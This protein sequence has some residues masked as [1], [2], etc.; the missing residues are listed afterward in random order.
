MD[1]YARIIVNVPQVMGEFDYQIPPEIQSRVK[2]GCLVKVPFGKQF[3]QG[4]VFSL[5]DSSEWQ[6]AK[7][8]QALLDDEPVLS[9]VQLLLARHLANQTLSSLAACI[10]MMLPPG[11]SQQADTL[12]SLNTYAHLSLPDFSKIQQRII[13]LIQQ[14]G[15]LR[16]RQLESAF[17]RIRWK[18]A[19]LSLVKSGMLLNQPVL[20]VSKVR[21]KRVRMVTLSIP[22]DTALENVKNFSKTEGIIQRRQSALTFLAKEN[23]PVQTTWVAAAS[24]CTL[25]DL[26][27]LSDEGLISLEELEIWRDPLDQVEAHPIPPPCLTAEQK[28]A[29]EKILDG[30]KISQQGKTPLPYL[31]HGVTSSG[32]TEIYLHAVQEVLN[33]DRQAIILVPEISLTPQTVNRFLSRFPG[34]VGLVHSKLSAGERYDTWR[35]ARAGLLQVVVGPRSALF[36]PFHDLGLIVIDECHDDSYFQDDAQPAYSAVEAALIFARI[37]NAVIVLG[38]ATPSLDLVY[39]ANKEGWERLE[40][41]VRI[42]AHRDV[43][44]KE[45]EALHQPVPD[46]P[47]KKVTTILPLPPVGIIDMRDELKS[48]NRSIFSFGLQKAL[49]D[50]LAN[51]QQAILFLN[52]RGSATYIFCRNCGYSLRCPRCDLP[53]TYHMD[54]NQLLCHT[55]GYQRN[56]PLR[57]PKCSSGQIKQY[58]TGTE[59]VEQTLKELF[60]SANLLRWDFETTRQ[61]GSHDLILAH[62]IRHN[63]DILIGT[64][65]LAKGLDLPL[66]TL[67]GVILADVG[68]N[69]PDYRSSERTFQLLTQ[70]AGRAGRSP[71]G[72]KVILQTFQPDHYAIQSAAHHD[73]AGFYHQELEIRRRMGYPPFSRLVKLE[74]RDLN[75]NKAE[76]MARA[77]S[78]QVHRWIEEGNHASTDLIGPTPCFFYKQSGYY[79]WQLILRG[80]DPASILRGKPLAQAR[81]VVDP[82]SLL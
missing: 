77:A 12:F 38:S 25:P 69:L 80:P 51:H 71:L 3:V 41:P 66:V 61:K 11:L 18:P 47:E 58:G 73:A 32:K 59:K 37:K 45:M 46:L 24:G 23:V 67:V 5:Q 63:A 65:M 54:Q 50:T 29:L 44:Q 56:L 39:R 31:L 26:Q 70:V 49:E 22:L 28:D 43:I 52:R 19:A 16:G 81:V 74:F 35:R 34:K 48:G 30:V 17:P 7:P 78:L 6:D 21:P 15:P 10:Q 1:L 75:P 79:R 82:P 62:F 64:Q 33:H 13:A 76:Q 53:L 42:L 8:I 60:P 4:V 27:R 57:C 40:L 2:P 55:C 72:G 68:L 14:R 20:P 9:E 36:T